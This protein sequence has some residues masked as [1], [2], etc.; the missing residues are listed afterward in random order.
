MLNNF[1]CFPSFQIVNMKGV[2]EET[3]Q[4]LASVD[5]GKCS[6]LLRQQYIKLMQDSKSFTHWMTASLY[7][8]SALHTVSLITLSL[9]S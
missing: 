2:S 3:K 7:M 8:R 6:S 4:V 5:A 9:V 1:T